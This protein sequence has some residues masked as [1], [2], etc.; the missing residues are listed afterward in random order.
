E[1]AL[2]PATRA[3]APSM[4]AVS[5]RSMDSAEAPSY[6]VVTVMT[7][8]S[9]SGS[10]RISTANRAARPAIAISV[11]RTKASTG[12]R[13]KSA[14]IPLSAA[15]EMRFIRAV[16]ASRACGGHRRLRLAV[17]MRVADDAHRRTVAHR[18]DALGHDPGGVAE[19]AG[20]Q[21]GI[22]VALDDADADAAR[23][24]VTVEHPD[25]GA[26]GA[27]LDRKRVD[28]GI[29]VARKLHGDLERHAGAEPVAVIGDA[30]LDVQRAA[31]RIDAVVDGA[32]RTAMGLVRTGDRDGGDGLADGNHAGEAF[33]HPEVD[34]ELRAVVDGGDLG[35]GGDRVADRHRQ[36][37][38]D[39]GDG[40]DDG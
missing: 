8:R 30:R 39:A 28:R 15:E 12:R 14:V 29:G 27:P 19:I 31:L 23:H 21:H 16:S 36:D 5:S 3:T 13:T 2:T 6:C 11:L 22:G 35:L 4:T 37:A 34:D 9:T 20:Y 25:I 1:I 7:G 32:D 40:R 17:L 33:R 24:A 26:V 38:D 10:S 18:V